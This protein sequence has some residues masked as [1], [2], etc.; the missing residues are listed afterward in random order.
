[1]IVRRH[2]GGKDSK[3]GVRRG[4]SQNLTISGAQLAALTCRSVDYWGASKV[5]VVRAPLACA[6]RRAL[7]TAGLAGAHKCALACLTQMCSLRNIYSIY[8]RT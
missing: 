4:L 7:W 2:G 6:L 1:M 3:A 8:S 5:K